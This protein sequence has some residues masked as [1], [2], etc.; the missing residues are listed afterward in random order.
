MKQHTIIHT[1]AARRIALCSLIMMTATVANAQMDNV[2]EVENDFRPTVQDATKINTLPEIEQPT[3]T[4]Y[5]VDYTTQSFPTTNYAFQPLWAARNQQLLKPGKKGFVSMAYGN[6]SNILGHLAYEFDLSEFDKLGVDL[7]T[8]G[9]KGNVGL[10]SS[11]DGEEWESRLFASRLKAGYTHRL[12]KQSEFFIKAGYGIDVFNY[13]PLMPNPYITDK[14]HDDRIDLSVGLTPYRFGRFGIG[15]DASLQTFSQKYENS[16]DDGVSE[17]LVAGQ[18]VPEYQISEQV[19]A[20]VALGADYA[21]YGMDALDGASQAVEGYTSF[22]ATPHV[23]YTSQSFDLKVGVYVDN[24]VNIAPDVDATLHVSPVLDVYVQAHGGDVFNDFRRFASM[25]PYWKLAHVAFDM[26]NQFDQ[27]RSRGGVR[28]K[29]FDC[30]ALDLSA[31][32]DISK[33]RAEIADFLIDGSNAMVYAPI[34]FADGHHFFANATAEFNYLDLVK[35]RLKAQ[36]NQWDTDLE[37]AGVNTDPLWRPVF[38]ADGSVLFQPLKGLSI[39]ADIL[40]E[41]FDK[42]DGR[43]HRQST[44]DLGATVSYTT[45]WN[46]TIYAKGQNLL[47]RKHDQYFMYRAQ[48]VSFMAGAAFS[49]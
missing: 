38:E 1:R 3:V 39:G 4:H 20:D 42:A 21:S 43:Y 6:N 10:I 28:L 15:A 32:Y 49:F 2:V 22:N 37:V 35:A 27:L 24:D 11:A 25:S 45:P 31:G 26:E 41:S 47:N 23:Y 29:P 34:I 17:L 18:V 44:I 46:L 40:F 30:L 7:S 9:Y 48:K 36:Y 16:F 13:Q 14:Q 19:K 33:H 8:R 5:N 12:D